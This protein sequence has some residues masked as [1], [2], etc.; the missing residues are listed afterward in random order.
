[1]RLRFEW[2]LLNL[3]ETDDTLSCYYRLNSATYITVHI[4]AKIARFTPCNSLQNYWKLFLSS[5]FRMNYSACLNI[6][7]QFSVL[8]VAKEMQKYVS[9]LVIIV[10]KLHVYMDTNITI[11]R[12]QRV[13]YTLVTFYNILLKFTCT[14]FC[15]MM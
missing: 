5:T 7:P 9:T 12:L 4:A 10:V 2:I 14:L 1:M 13:K 6:R 8:S 11:A 3:S 15:N